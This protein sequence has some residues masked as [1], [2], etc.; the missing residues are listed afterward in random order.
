MLDLIDDFYKKLEDG[1]NWVLGRDIVVLPKDRQG[2]TRGAG[3]KKEDFVSCK[4]CDGTG[5]KGGSATSN[6]GPWCEK[7]G[8]YGEYPKEISEKEEKEVDSPVGV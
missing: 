1:V 5:R 4:K 2:Y 3:Y 6:R 8:G 7:C